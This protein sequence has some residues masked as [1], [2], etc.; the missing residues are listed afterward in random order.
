MGSNS[1][2]CTHTYNKSKTVFRTF[3]RWIWLIDMGKGNFGHQRSRGLKIWRG[4][5]TI[6]N[7][8][9]ML[10]PC[11][12]VTKDLLGWFRDV[13]KDFKNIWF[14]QV[15]V[16][17]NVVFRSNQKWKYQNISTPDMIET[18]FFLNWLFFS[19]QFDENVFLCFGGHLLRRYFDFSIFG[20]IGRRHF[21][22][23]WPEK[24]KKI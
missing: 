16:H 1:A 21:G 11:K 22:R 23:Q 8:V 12:L 15:I 7:A 3:L 10:E 20:V 18:R 24:I 2:M 17:Q 6:K 5:I 14:F 13:L 4:K 19:K 9:L